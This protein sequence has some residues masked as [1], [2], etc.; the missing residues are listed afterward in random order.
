MGEGIRTTLPC[1]NRACKG[2]SAVKACAGCRTVYYC[3]RECQLADRPFHKSICKQ[4]VTPG[5]GLA[6]NDPAAILP[7][8]TAR[9]AVEAA[10][11][12]LDTRFAIGS[13]RMPANAPRR[14][15]NVDDDG[16]TF[17]GCQESAFAI[18]LHASYLGSAVERVLG[19]AG[20]MDLYTTTLE[21]TL[22]GTCWIPLL[23]VCIGLARLLQS[24]PTNGDAF[25]RSDRGLATLTRVLEG[26]TRQ[27]AWLIVD[28][29]TRCVSSAAGV[30][31]AASC[32]LFAR[33]AI[34]P[35]IQG[36]ILA[37]TQMANSPVGDRAA[38]SAGGALYALQQQAFRCQEPGCS[39]IGRMGVDPA[40]LPVI[41]EC[42]DRAMNV[43]ELG[44]CPIINASRAIFAAMESETY[45]SGANARALATPRVCANLT[46]ACQLAVDPSF[47]HEDLM[48]ETKRAFTAAVSR[49]VGYLCNR[50]QADV[51]A[52]LREA[53][54][55]VVQ[56]LQIASAEGHPFL[57]LDACF[58]IYALAADYGNRASLVNEGAVELVVGMLKRALRLGAQSPGM[59]VWVN[60]A[61]ARLMGDDE[62]LR[63]LAELPKAATCQLLVDSLRHALAEEDR[64][65]F[66]GITYMA[67]LGTAVSYWGRLTT[68]APACR[69]HLVAAGAKQ[70]VAQVLALAEAAGHTLAVEDLRYLRTELSRRLSH[71]RRH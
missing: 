29:A 60:E 36:S 10:A 7:L 65:A 37:A 32:D 13:E 22:A 50:G 68:M 56:M 14:V 30:I 3:S 26:A 45:Y 5:T 59:H 39:H 1:H 67:R 51:P 34:F 8:D 66:S 31:S 6:P 25:C 58:A 47:L 23:P 15:Y 54:P 48:Q 17:D 9:I 27:G 41:D 70:A 35:V 64:A 62:G 49:A 63:R 61:L 69:K 38:F 20:A 71:Q 46:R 55:Y 28:A 16:V 53:C 12:E 33:A 2:N 19:K 21:R 18:L 11:A 44:A 43:A 4:E 24:N 57:Q 42:L 40:L 52:R